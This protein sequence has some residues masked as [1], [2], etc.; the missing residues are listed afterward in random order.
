[1]PVSWEDI[2]LAFEFVSGGDTDEHQ[3]FL[4]KHTG[5]LYWRSDTVDG[6][7]ELPDDIDDDEKYLQIPH[8]RDLDL[9]SRSSW[10]SRVNSYQRTSMKF[11]EFSTEKA[12][13]P[14][15]RTC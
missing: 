8:K 9:A 12:P 3:A 7:D 10:S 15:S 13:T 5:K 4:C 2:I 11:G 6:L 14:D 1:M